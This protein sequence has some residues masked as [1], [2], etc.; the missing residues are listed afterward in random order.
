MNQFL[1]I[2]YFKVG[3]TYGRKM[4]KGY[5]DSK[6]IFVSEPKIAKSLERVAPDSYESRRHNTIDRTNPHP[7]RADYFCHKLHIDQTEKLVMFG[8]TH[9]IA[10]D[11]FSGMIVCHLTLPIKNNKLIYE[12]IYRYFNIIILLQI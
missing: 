4:M 2:F 12:H 10:V 5:L 1:R 9:V 3:E 8:T 7:Y 11:G 6:E